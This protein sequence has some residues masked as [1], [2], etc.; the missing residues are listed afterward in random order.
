MPGSHTQ[1]N[2]L[3]ITWRE[4]M[5]LDVYVKKGNRFSRLTGDNGEL[6]PADSETC[7]RPPEKAI[8]FRDQDPSNRPHQF[9]QGRLRR[10][11]RISPSERQS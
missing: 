11:G 9:T 7:A 10:I 1:I 4:N 8:V 2:I 5:A 6:L 3:G